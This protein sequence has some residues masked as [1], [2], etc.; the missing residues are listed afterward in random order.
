MIPIIL[1]QRWWP[2]Q[3]ESPTAAMNR[4]EARNGFDLTRASSISKPDEEG[5]VAASK[6]AEPALSGM[7]TN[8][9]L[10]DQVTNR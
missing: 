7:P 5:Q 9:A 4:V 3:V 8:A 2:G 10:A 1:L 6:P